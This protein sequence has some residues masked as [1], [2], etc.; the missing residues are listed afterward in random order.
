[1]GSVGMCIVKEFGFDF[2]VLVYIDFF[3]GVLRYIVWEYWFD[4][5]LLC[6]LFSFGF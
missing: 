1:M 5:F 3:G 6:S 2:F 4:S